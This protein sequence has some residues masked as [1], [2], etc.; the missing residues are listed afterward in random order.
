MQ[1]RQR[2]RQRWSAHFRIRSSRPAPG[3]ASSWGRRQQPAA[4]RQ[5]TARTA[6]R[7]LHQEIC[8][9][10]PSLQVRQRLASCSCMLELFHSAD[11]AA[12][13]ASGDLLGITI[14]AGALTASD[15]TSVRKPPSWRQL[16]LQQHPVASGFRKTALCGTSASI[17][18]T[19]S[20]TP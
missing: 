18:Q 20:S 12:A 15:L 19:S 4:L 13:A 1:A 10:P 2:R 11:G 7:L 5:A 6:P 17:R 3:A 16:V 8:R 14:F 9:A